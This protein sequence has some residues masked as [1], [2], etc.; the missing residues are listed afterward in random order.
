[1]AFSLFGKKQPD[2]KPDKPAAPKIEARRPNAPTPSAPPPGADDGRSLDFT[3]YAPP[4]TSQA[5]QSTAPASVAPPSVAPTAKGPPSVAAPPSSAPPAAPAG[6]EG[7]SL[8]FGSLAAA[9]VGQQAPASRAPE[10]AKAPEPPKKK[11]LKKPLDSILC[12]EVEEGSG[13]DVPPAIEEAAILYA[14]GQTEESRA[15][16][17]EAL[18]GEDLGA[19][20]LQMWLMLFD[21]LQQLGR[22]AEFEEKALDF[23]V[24]FERS[25]P[26]V[27]Q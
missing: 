16:A 15:R 6:A 25:A 9:A 19:W 10:P 22:K 3:N 26:N 1:M 12:I 5:P 21:V 11:A 27:S 4:S 13:V 20:K 18:D 14:N 23:V 8:D 2:K 7:F 24:K 17:Q